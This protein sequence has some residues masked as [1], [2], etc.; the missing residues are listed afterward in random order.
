MVKVTFSAAGL[1]Y[2][3]GQYMFLCLPDITLWEWHPFSL[4]SCPGQAEAHMHV[5]ALGDWPARLEKLAQAQVG[6]AS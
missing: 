5:R 4:S 2:T 1:Q 3:A 6:P